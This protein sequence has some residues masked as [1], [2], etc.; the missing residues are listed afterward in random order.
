MLSEQGYTYSFYPHLVDIVVECLLA[1]LTQIVAH[2]CPVG[3]QFQSDVSQSEVFS[4]LEFS[5]F[6]HTLQLSFQ[7]GGYFG[8]LQHIRLWLCFL[9]CLDGLEVPTVV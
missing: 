2:V 4:Q 8:G 9:F 1:H 7:N 3:I 6:N 5:P